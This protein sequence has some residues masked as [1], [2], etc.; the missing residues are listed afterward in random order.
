MMNHPLPCLSF[1]SAPSAPQNLTGTSLHSQSIFLS[2]SP[3]SLP[4]GVIR[5]YRVNVTEVETGI[6]FTE[7]T[8][9]ATTIAL[10]S[11]HPYYNYRCQVSAY[12]VEVGP[13]VDIY[14]RTQED[15]KML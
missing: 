14:I 1:T 11:L 13:Y 12:S 5:E 3:P 2:W 4:N 8:T 6:I 9:H 15:G 10:D 7:I